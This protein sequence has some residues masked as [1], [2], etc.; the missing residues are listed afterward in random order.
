MIIKTNSVDKMNKFIP[1]FL[2]VLSLNLA[3]VLALNITL[4]DNYRQ[5]QTIIAELKGNVI[6]PISQ[7]N[8]AFYDGRKIIPMIY[9]ISKLDDK[10]F[11]YAV[12]P[13]E[14]RNYTLKIKDI[15]FFEQGREKKEDLLKNFS[16]SG[17]VAE[18][19][20]SPGFVT[21]SK[22]FSLKVKNLNDDLDVSTEFGKEKSTISIGAGRTKDLKFSTGKIQNS[23]ISYLKVSSK[24]MAYNIPVMVLK[25][26]SFNYSDQP[27]VSPLFILGPNE[28]SLEIIRGSK[29]SVNLT[30]ENFM[31]EE[32]KEL[33]L[34]Y[35]DDLAG[36]L[37]IQ[38]LIISNLSPSSI[39]NIQLFITSPNRID[40]FE[41]SITAF[42]QNYSD[43]TKVFISVVNELN[44]SRPSPN[45]ISSGSLNSC[46]NLGGIRC[47]S[48]EACE[49]N[50]T[51]SIEGSCC[52][53]KCISKSQAGG[54]STGK[55]IIFI[56]IIAVVIVLFFLYRKYKSPP[57]TPEK[58]IEEMTTKFDK[59]FKSP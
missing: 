4:N 42:S 37:E 15:H 5:G 46:V 55:I 26:E 17:E 39:K 23:G 50:Y 14:E 18:F 11:L 21:S 34:S 20:V 53:G 25:N 44:A 56:I 27:S 52:L 29:T 36:I 3:P 45:N 2:L 22:D 10:Y 38:P 43:S 28:L 24:G 33:R 9:S 54:G 30:I 59:K 51:N 31:Q 40:D 41:G 6:T 13:V 35:S 1:L 48:D 8:V 47:F 57:K 32:I 12:L 16:V 49:G 19:S 58:K 7:D